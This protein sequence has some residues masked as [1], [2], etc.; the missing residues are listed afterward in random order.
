[1]IVIPAL[2][3]RDGAC[4][5]LVGGAYAEERVRLADPVAVAREW[6][7]RGFRHLHVVDLDAATGAGANDALVGEVIR[8]VPARTQVGGGVRS[9]ARAD[10]LLALGAARVIVGTRAF[11]APDWLDA[12]ARRHPGRVVVAADVRGRRVVTH[13]WQ[14]VL[15]LDVGDAVR[16]LRG[17]PLGGLL[18]TAVHLEGQ[19]AGTD[20]PLMADV[21]AA[22][23]VPVFAAGGVTTMDDLRALAGLGV[24][25]AVVGMAFYTGALDP[26]A[27]LQEFGG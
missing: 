4:V 12:L 7:V 27:V 8:T 11:A 5:Q 18:V 15:D 17:L 16:R 21:V 9:A 2:D 14:R 23:A 26:R 6:A 1:M 13:G 20:R 24:A 3:L 25:G 19:L 22:S 10:L